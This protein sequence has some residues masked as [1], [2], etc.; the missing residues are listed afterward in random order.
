[1]KVNLAMGL[2]D[3]AIAS[4][5]AVID[6]GRYALMTSRF[7]VDKDDPSHDVIWDLHQEPNKALAEN[8]ERIWSFIGDESLTE[9]GASEKLSI[10]RQTVPYWGGAGKV[11]TPS[12]RT[13]TTDQPLG[14]TVGEGKV[15]I[16]QVAMTGRGIGR[17]RPSP[18]SQFE[19][20]DDPNDLRHTYPNWWTMEDLVYNNPDLKVKNDPYYGKNLQLYDDEGGIL[21]TDTIRSWFDWPHYKLFIPDPTDNTPDG[22]HGDWYAMR[23]AET[24][25]LRAEAYVWKNDPVNAAMDLNAVRTRA[26]A[27]AYDPSEVNIGT[28]LDERARELYYEEPRK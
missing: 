26:G 19:L 15:E 3:D 14:A 6:G 2:F 10:M 28:V 18:W 7:G 8:T 22:G 23:L 5:S 11:K 1:T 25:L 24:Y 27:A 17:F 16:D 4:A 20:W 13:G 9:D 21:C 12:G